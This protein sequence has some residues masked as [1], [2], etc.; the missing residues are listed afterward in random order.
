MFEFVNIEGGVCQDISR[1][2]V[3]MAYNNGVSS[4]TAAAA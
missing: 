1:T 2:V 4:D 3:G